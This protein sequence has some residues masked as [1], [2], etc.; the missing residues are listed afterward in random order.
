MSSTSSIRKSRTTRSRKSRRAA[1]P[2]TPEAH[3]TATGGN[4]N[5]IPPSLF[6]DLLREWHEKQNK[7]VLN[8]EI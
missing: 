4:G 6:A 1:F 3:Q 8:W 5:T 2:R 7:Y